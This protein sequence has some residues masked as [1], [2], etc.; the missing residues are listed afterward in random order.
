MKFRKWLGAILAVAMSATMAFAIAA[1]H[2]EPEEKP[3][4]EGPETGVYY[5]DAGTDEYTIALNNVDQFTF[6]VMGENKTGTYA[7]EGE[8][9]TFDFARAEDD[10]IEATLSDNVITLTYNNASMRFLKKINYTVSYDAQGGGTVQASTVI[11]GKTVAKP[12]DPERDGYT[13]IGWYTD[14]AYMTPFLFDVQPVTG[15]ITLYAYW[16]ETS[17][18]NAEYTV[19]FDLGYDAEEAPAPVQT[20]EGCVITTALPVP[21]REGYTFVGW[22]VSD[23][24][25]ADKLTYQYKAGMPLN[26]DT[27]LFAV[28]QSD[29]EEGLAQPAVEVTASGIVW[30]AVDGAATYSVEIKTADGTVVATSNGAQT[31]YDFDFSAKDAGEY[32]VTVSAW[33]TQAMTGEP[34]TTVRYYGNKALPRVTVFSVVE[35]STLV[36]EGVANAQRY[37]ITV[38]CGDDSHT[39]TDVSL[40]SATYY[41]FVNCPMQEG[42]I[43]FTVTAEADGYAS[44]VSKTFVYNR[45][46]SMV[47]GLSYDAATETI[48]WDA[49][50]DA[51]SYV[52]SVNGTVTDVGNVTS[53]SVKNQPAGELSFSIY[54]RTTGYNSPVPATL[55]VTKTSLAAPQNL[56]VSGSK[57]SWDAVT[58]ATGYTVKIDG[59]EYPAASNEFDLTDYVDSGDIVVSVRANG[60]ANSL[61]SDAAMLSYL[62]MRGSLVYANGVIT[63]NPV[64]GASYYE[65]Q[66]ND[67]AWTKYETNVTSAAVKLTQRGVNV[68]RVRF[69]ANGQNYKAKTL[70]VNAYMV[71]FDTRGGSAVASVYVAYGDTLTLPEASRNGYEFVGW[72]N[73]PA[74]LSNN[75]TRFESPM[76][77]EETNDVLIYADWQNASYSAVLDAQGG[78]VTQANIEIVYDKPFKLEVPSTVELSQAGMKDGRYVFV[79]WYEARNGIGERYTDASGKSLVDWDHYTDDVT[80]YA[81]W[82]EAFDYDL[83]VQAGTGADVY[84][85]KMGNEIGKLNPNTITSVT[86]PRTYNGLPVGVMLASAFESCT[87]LTEIYIPDTLMEIG[88]SDD[89]GGPFVKCSNLTSVNIY[90]TGE[91][92]VSDYYSVDGVL[93]ERMESGAVRLAFFPLG[94]TGA[95][96]MPEGVQILPSRIFA[97]TKLTSVTLPASLTTIEQSAFYNCKQLTEVIFK[98]GS[99][100]L[101]IRDRAFHNCTALKSITLPQRLV[102][103]GTDNENISGVFTGCTAMTTFTVENGGATQSGLSARGGYL[104]NAAGTTILYCPLGKTGEVSIPNGIETIGESAFAGRDKITKIVI[105]YYVETVDESAFENCEALRDVTFEGM[106]GGAFE[107]EIGERA[108][109]GC[110]SLLNL[111]FAENCNVTLIGERAFAYCDGLQK[112]SLPAT[113]ETVG[114]EAFRSCSGLGELTIN[115]SSKTGISFGESAFLNCSTLKTINFSANVGEFDFISVFDGCNALMTINVDE[116]N[117]SFSS[118]NGDLYNKDKTAILFY[119]RLK[120]NYTVP[121][122]V[123]LKT[124]G[125]GAFADNR[126]ITSVVIPATVTSIEAGAFESLINLTSLTITDGDAKLAIGE[127]AFASCNKLASVSLPQRVTSVGDGAFMENG[128]LATLTLVNGLETIGSQAFYGTAITSVT[129]PASVTKIGGAAFAEC[130]SLATFTFA[131]ADAE[132]GKALVLGDSTS[133]L[134][135]IVYGTKVEELVLPARL[136]TIGDYALAGIA[137]LT[138]I[139]FDAN[140]TLTEIGDYALAQTPVNYLTIPDTVTSIGEGAFAECESLET[141]TLPKSLKTLGDDAFYGCTLLNAITLDASNTAYKAEDGVLYNAGKTQIVAFPMSKTGTFTMPLT[142]T[143]VAA[144]QFQNSKVSQVILH[145]KVTEIG[146]YAFDASAVTEMAIPAS[147]TTIGTYAFRNTASLKKVVF[148]E[149]LLPETPAEDEET[150][151]E[152]T[153]PDEGAEE[154]A[155]VSTQAEGETS[156]ETAEDETEETPQEVISQL[157]KLANYTFDGSAIEEIKLPSN[158][159]EIGTY[160]FRNTQLKSVVIPATVTKIGNYAFSGIKT[161]TSVAFENNTVLTSIGNYAF[162]NSGDETAQSVTASLPVGTSGGWTLGT[163][164]FYG[165]QFTSV[166]F[167][168]GTTIKTLPARSFMNM[169]RLTSFTIPA[170]VTSTAA[171]STSYGVFYGSGLTSITIPSTLTSIGTYTFN[172]VPN[173]QEVVFEDPAGAEELK[174]GN[175]T[176]YKCVALEEISI[177]ARVKALP[178]SVFNGCTALDTIHFSEKGTLTE[179]GN[180]AFAETAFSSFTVPE[181][182]TKLGGTSY[183]TSP[184]YKCAALASITLPASMK[185]VTPYSFSTGYSTT[186]VNTLEN[187]FVADKNATYCDI[188]GVLFSADKKQLIAYPFGRTATSY[189]VPE[190]TEVIGDRAF[191]IYSS[192]YCYPR[193]LTAITFPD[194]LKTIS[195]YAFH[196]N[197]AI[198]SLTIPES[199]TEID[200][201]A[202]TEMD[203]LLSVTLPAALT[204]IG[205]RA[206][207]SCDVLGTLTIPENSKL[208]AIGGYAFYNCAIRSLHLPK[209][210]LSLGA[211]AFY[212]NAEL[213]TVEFAEDGALKSIGTYAFHSCTGL[214]ELTIPAYIEEIE[215]YA[216]YLGSS[217]TGGLERVVFEEGSHLTTIGARAFYYQS[218]LKTI[219]EA[220][221]E[222]GETVYV[223]PASLVELDDNAFYECA[224]LEYIRFAENGA[225]T[226][227]GGNVFAYCDA[228][229]E[230]VLPDTVTEMGSSVFTSCH[231]L[232]RVVLP[233]NLTELPVSTFS[234][235]YSLTTVTYHGDKAETEGVVRLP[236]G[237]SSIGNNSFQ[238]S[239]ISAIIIPA[240]VTEI[241]NNVFAVTNLSAAPNNLTSVVFEGSSLSSLGNSVFENCYSLTEIEIPDG[242]S[243]L[244]DETFLNCTSLESFAVPASVTE[245]GESVFEG[246]ISLKSIEILSG[247]SAIGDSAFADCVL[248][249]SFELR[250]TIVSL[251]ENVF[252]NCRNIEFNLDQQNAEFVL[253]NG[254]LYNSVKTEIYS[255]YNPDEEVVIPDTVRALPDAAFAGTAIRKITIPDSVTEIGSDVFANCTNLE[256]VVFEGQLTSIGARAFR[257]CISIKSFNVPWTVTSIGQYSFEN[258]TGLE[259]LTFDD[260]GSSVLYLDDYSFRNCTALKSLVLPYRL[261]N[262]GSGSTTR[263]GIGPH[264]FEG[265]TSLES[266]SFE[267]GTQEF[268]SPLTVGSYAFQGCTKLKMVS[269][270]DF[271]RFYS[272][273]AGGEEAVYPTIGSYAFD[274]CTSLSDIDFGSC[275]PYS[276][277]VIGTLYYYIG[278]HAFRNCVS[279]VDLALPDQ[280]NLDGYGGSGEY[281][282]QGCSGLRSVSLPAS[283]RY[284][285]PQF[286]SS[287]DDYESATSVFAGCA[288]LEDVTIR[289]AYGTIAN[290]DYPEFYKGMIGEMWFRD[291][292]NLKTVKF[293]DPANLFTIGAGAFMNCSS[294]TELSLPSGLV[295]I[296]DSAFAGCSGIQSMT[297]PE[298]LQTLGTED[299][300]SYGLYD[301][302]GVFTGTMITS[303]VIPASVNEVGPETFMGSAITNISVAAPSEG[304]TVN[305]VA[306]NNVLYNADKTILI[307]YLS[308]E[309]VFRIPD[310]VTQ[311]QTAAFSGSKV[312]QV[313]I[314][315]TVTLISEY[316]FANCTSLTSVTFE[317]TT[318]NMSSYRT[319]YLAD[320]IFCGCTALETVTL[321][322]AIREIGD[323]A[324]EGCTSLKTVELPSTLMAIGEFAFKSSGLTSIT[325]PASLGGDGLTEGAFAFCDDLTTINVTGNVNFVIEDGIL[326]NADKTTLIRYLPAARPQGETSYVIP[327]SVTRIATGAFDGALNLTSITIGKNVTAA[328]SSYYSGFDYCTNIT[329]F[330][331][332]E[333]NNTFLAIDGNLYKWEG[334]ALTFVAYASG[335]SE[336]SFVLKIPDSVEVTGRFYIGGSA[337]AGSKLKEI[338]ITEDVDTIRQNVF[339]GWTSD[340][341]IYLLDTATSFTPSWSDLENGLVNATVKYVPA[342]EFPNNNAPVQE[343]RN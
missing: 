123:T 11:N 258:C 299:Y 319:D 322:S 166:T 307:A 249:E 206:F 273:S 213:S 54:P 82:I 242:I 227:L 3:R 179:I 317:G 34:A 39:H 220:I 235:C 6:L 73:I 1:C 248:L 103:L 260:E 95:Y 263:E 81:Y 304:G 92:L 198:T 100:E 280:L 246:C 272:Y 252:L 339:N 286:P 85:V 144:Y 212:G 151:G 152:E 134:G 247:V 245:I 293:E 50:P 4:E 195:G 230:V 215:S 15:N 131:P 136:T 313:T 128:S 118:V 331:V 146:N 262:S 240:A 109:Y 274:G 183:S 221:V 175:G 126:N 311:I 97:A 191:G 91:V 75:G 253:E 279:L 202:F 320:F 59:T 334:S 129:I 43:R 237:I 332:A 323:N 20:V 325:L 155:G 297:L 207:Y 172:N 47:T 78:V 209:T 108:F 9:L 38:D 254:I 203:G 35:P 76:M 29:D 277:N 68:I 239:G 58:D 217:T 160:V 336:E 71:E 84:A 251:G 99:T 196:Y 96:V 26:A 282:F 147:V 177:P 77:F 61:W 107:T 2:D 295:E 330:K 122:G 162:Q 31:H 316:A 187:I 105:P 83:T 291:C 116:N 148:T 32:V 268:T 256:E 14:T 88:S 211:R 133:S 284:Y 13:F 265:C 271:L 327:D 69:N 64:F 300:N 174:L 309:P 89:T 111:S 159:E 233:S 40:G 267:N 139:T 243:L 343:G 289:T 176:F 257:N 7:L 141:V 25:S 173:L 130:A 143:K 338:W 57:L 266:V 113:I 236:E 318:V 205:D 186:N 194:T 250:S 154:D 48:R 199:V 208:E 72:F 158:L 216:F 306:E 165:S 197:D 312:E 98:G 42:G 201:Y 234:S 278:H 303:L 94:R 125:A 182:V 326:Y 333:G 56:T 140:S 104:C 49:V 298:G 53:V 153:T 19:D 142:I 290:P 180:T 238:N 296:R 90:E 342:E 21:E 226:T 224:S 269:L 167:A 24:D 112:L 63:W 288:N 16:L 302:K 28:W 185:D 225:L 10:D 321:P 33:E 169:T 110:S 80:L 223:M 45:E 22:Y 132:N 270:P 157:K 137:G 87:T 115:G 44:S 193:Y 156:G 149:I 37:Y 124:I 314:P 5:F 121:E 150:P 219:G 12:E 138:D 308:A 67:G 145:D 276:G 17:P 60:A 292:V 170:S 222:N 181:G 164:A 192:I 305:L 46:L 228:L 102:S 178:T 101:T 310:T 8:T 86:V 23:Y 66:V 241:G 264:T 74:G 36:F 261:R 329:E 55:K 117:A 285:N 244:D 204:T 119:S 328:G 52:V 27:T 93:F 294:L 200:D 231:G 114:E 283:K 341:T 135:G 184:F 229:T 106:D 41:N 337:F 79:G 214:K 315:A 232:E 70:S 189:A 190:G 188:D 281:A 161:L 168:E 340:Q 65:V 120:G 275:L 335:K 62:G 324:F 259:S 51:M 218:K 210:L 287:S 255:V 171:G 18:V 163:Y 127:N 30:E 301:G